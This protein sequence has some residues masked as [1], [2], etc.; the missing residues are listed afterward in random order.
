M[1]IL[2]AVW[3]LDPFFKV[4]GLGDVARSF[5]AAL[6]EKGVDIRIVLPYYKVLK[7]GRQRRVMVGEIRCFYD[8]KNRDV[9][10]YKVEHP[11]SKIP[12]YL[13]K[14][15]K[16]LDIAKFPDTF[17]FFSLAIAEIIKSNIL[18]WAPDIIHCN[19]VHTS[20]VPLLLKEKGVQS[21]TV[22]TI[23]NLSYQGRTVIDILDKLEI[24]ASKCAVLH[25]EIKSKKICFLIEGIIHAD[26]ITTVSPTYA[27]EILTE[28]YG[29]GLEDVLSGREG[30]IF[31]ILNGIDNNWHHMMANRGIK[32]PYFLTK[33]GIEKNNEL[34][35]YS[36]EEGKKLNKLYLQKKLGLKIDKSIPLISFIGRFDPFQKGIDLLH[37]ML[38]RINLEK[39]EFAILGSGDPNW[40]E[41]FQW[42]AKFYPKNISCNFIFDDVLAHQIYAASDFILIP[43]KFE[44]CG[45][46][47]MVAMFFGTLPIAHETGGLRD[48]IK[49]GETG[50][51]FD[52]YST[53]SLE[54]SLNRAVEIW[55][56]DK[57]RYKTMVENAM[58]MDFSW[59]RSAREYL[60]LYQKLVD[61][62]L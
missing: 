40:E 27:R 26:A 24:E 49:D 11:I 50:F 62:E 39:Y 31:G 59:D 16:Y 22:L 60:N 53:I 45:L 5:P 48:S 46:V 9:E 29:S 42:L 52:K 56:Q 7:L 30:R 55:L 17:A 6:K 3:E 35:V 58:K 43:S 36:W 28:E 33:V 37:K 21:K 25:W 44:P 23:H 38:R 13:I 19:D 15:K 8:N 4:G 61:G 14:N 1:K 57:K 51:L 34:K 12:V 47:Q 32:Y 10:I 2:F 41:R 54:H 18:S 20:L